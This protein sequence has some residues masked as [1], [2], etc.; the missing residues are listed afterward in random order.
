[1]YK[2]ACMCVRIFA[3]ASAPP[4]QLTYPDCRGWQ[5]VS[6]S[7]GN[8]AGVAEGECIGLVVKR[9]KIVS[10]A[11][12]GGCTVCVELLKEGSKVGVSLSGVHLQGDRQWFFAVSGE[13]EAIALSRLA[14]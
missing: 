6:S 9:E 13:S 5:F 14:V 11:D 8:E 1:M 3:R 10:D 12:G 2:K 7:T 4:R